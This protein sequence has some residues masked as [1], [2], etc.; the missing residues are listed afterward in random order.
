MSRG[1]EL[2]MFSDYD[3]AK[4]STLVRIACNKA[5]CKEAD[6]KNLPESAHNVECLKGIQN[7]DTLAFF[8]ASFILAVDVRDVTTVLNICSGMPFLFTDTLSRN[9]SLLL[10]T[11]NLP[12]WFNAVKTGCTRDY[13][14]EV[15]K[16]FNGVKKEL[17]NL[18]IRDRLG[19]EVSLPDNTFLL[20]RK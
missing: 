8:S 20:E 13:D 9:H 18:G 17:D 14:P 16:I 5:V 6:T 15:R 7:V 2:V 19:T 10:V 11:G 3:L 12:Q 1:A 4:L